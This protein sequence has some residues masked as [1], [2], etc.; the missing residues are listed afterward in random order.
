MKNKIKNSFNRAWKTYD[1]YCNVQKTVCL[2]AIELL[3]QYGKTYPQVADF[4]CGTGMS[5]LCLSEKI[6]FEK[7]KAID[8][9]EKLS[10]IAREKIN[11][12]R[13]D[14]VLSD[15]DDRLFAD[16]T[17]D[18]IFCNMGLQWSLNISSTLSLFYEYLKNK[19]LIAFSLPLENTFSEL[20]VPY[21]NTFYT[22]REILKTLED[23]GCQVEMFYPEI[24]VEQYSTPLKALQ[25]IKS[26]GANCVVNE[27]RS[28]KNIVTKKMMESFFVDPKFVSLTHHV[29]IFIAR[30]S[31]VL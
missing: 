26:V 17:F 18:L 3:L 2:K 7:M 24:V 22:P 30:K 9:S 13:I 5:T 28:A 19:G 15:F 27:K 10:E 31:K 23:I 25:S 12:N 20:N 21:K 29:G 1:V 14:L 4:A 16:Q 11:D 6:D 8:F